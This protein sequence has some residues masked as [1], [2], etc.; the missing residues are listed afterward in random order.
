VIGG[1]QHES[2]DKRCERKQH[3]GGAAASQQSAALLFVLSFPSSDQ[4][5]APHKGRTPSELRVC[6]GGIHSLAIN[7]RGV[8]FPQ[9]GVA[10]R[11]PRVDARHMDR[12][13]LDVSFAA[14][15]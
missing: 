12:Q 14:A 4:A 3:E 1:E 7:G 10:H 6:R 15:W 13:K 5:A 11:Y 9:H 2:R 8:I